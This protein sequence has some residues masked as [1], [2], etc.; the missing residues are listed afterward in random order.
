MGYNR[1]ILITGFLGAG[2]TTLMQA[3][4]SA[5][6]DRKIGVIV[7][8]FGSVNIDAV[9]LRRDGIAMAELSNGS[10][11][12]ACIKDNFLKALIEMSGRELDFI[13]IEASGLA[14]PSNMG[15]ILASIGAQVRT[16]YDYRG[17]LCVIDAEN[18]LELCDLLPALE[19]QV[20][21]SATAIINK[22]DLAPEKTIMDVSER[23][24]E[25]N[26]SIHIYIT[27]FC[28][29]DIKKA[30]NDLAPVSKEASETTNTL[31]TRPKTFVLK[32]DRILP[33]DALEKFLESVAAYSYRIKGFAVT[34]RGNFEISGVGRHIDCAKWDAPLADT[35][36][37][38]ISAVGIR[39]LSLITAALEPEL[40]GILG[41]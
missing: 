39:M 11:F 35:E 34:D 37:V 33:F 24:S 22:A 38:V 2:K 21:Y 26:P 40:K 25:I 4:I 9:L 10:I 30:I 13:F 5:Y 16:P 41:L 31:E 36:F 3:L 14:D 1:L 15:Q 12:C 6:G 20:E 19:H 28:R 18:F 27:S 23:I 7:N 8:E 29:V 17:A 32:A